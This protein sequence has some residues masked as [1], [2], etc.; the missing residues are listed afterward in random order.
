MHIL[1][2]LKMTQVDLLLIL[3]AVSLYL[4]DASKVKYFCRKILIMAY[5]RFCLLFC[6]SFA[7]TLPFVLAL[8]LFVQKTISQTAKIITDKKLCHCYKIILTCLLVHF[9][10]SFVLVFSFARQLFP[11]LS[12]CVHISTSWQPGLSP[13]VSLLHLQ[14]HHRYFSQY[15]FFCI[16]L[17]VYL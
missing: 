8:T 17:E 15:S 11:E 12:H 1:L 10:P 5:Q 9:K 4:I 14:I 2:F 16:C 6:S 7:F 13:Q 3:E